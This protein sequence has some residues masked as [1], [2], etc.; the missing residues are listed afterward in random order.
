MVPSPLESLPPSSPVSSS[1]SMTCTPLFHHYS[2]QRTQSSL[3]YPPLLRLHHHLFLR[4][5]IIA[6]TPL[7]HSAS[8][9]HQPATIILMHSLPRLQTHP[10]IHSIFLSSW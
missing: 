4:H 9:A 5:S 6:V 10:P 7:P 1:C 2:L 8:V 3:S